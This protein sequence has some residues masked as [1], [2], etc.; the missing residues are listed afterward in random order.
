MLESLKSS[1]DAATEARVKMEEVIQRNISQTEA[2]INQVQSTVIDDHVIKG[3]ALGFGVEDVLDAEIIGDR[4]E[5][6]TVQLITPDGAT[7]NLHENAINQIADKANVPMKFAN[8]LLSRGRWGA[9]LLAENF[10]K[11][12]GHGNGTRYLVRSVRDN[13]RGFMSD[14]YRRLDVRPLLDAFIG[15]CQ[16]IGAV[17]IQGFA[18]DTRVGIRAILPVVFEPVPGECMVFGVNWQNSDFGKGANSLSLFLMRLWCLNGAT[19]DELLRQ[20]HLGKKLDDNL[21]FSQRTIELDTLA[22]ISKLR[23]VVRF[24]FHESNV[25]GTLEAIKTANGHEID[26]KDAMAILKPRLTS[27]EI[28]AAIQAYNSP[29]IVT[30]PSGNTRYR[31]SNAISWIS[32][33]QGA[34]TDRRLELDRFAG[35]LIGKVTESRVVEV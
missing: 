5:R 26:A 15:E 9:E 16:T 18:T 24:A 22:N 33:A 7:F 19:M 11:I 35:E 32:Q 27:G 25:R 8:E 13:V 1:S 2:V 28:D 10:G 20:V 12:Y 6:P 30:L 31:L 17:P 4:P 3:S 21:E 29:D 14:K 34:T 23:D